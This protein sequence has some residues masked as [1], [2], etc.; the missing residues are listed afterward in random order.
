MA[1]TGGC[2]ISRVNT[3][4]ILK[5]RGY[6][7]ILPKMQHLSRYLSSKPQMLPKMQDYSSPEPVG[8]GI[9]AICAGIPANIQLWAG[10]V[11]IVATFRPCK[12]IFV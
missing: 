5:V 6:A 8:R 10:Q 4:L 12:V 9:V 1:L 3:A 7:E 2:N 11:A